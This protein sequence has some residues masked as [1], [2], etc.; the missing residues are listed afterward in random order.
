MKKILLIDCNW[1][2]NTFYFVCK[3]ELEAL[4]GLNWD[5]EKVTSVSSKVLTN[6]LSIVATEEYDE[7]YTFFD[8]GGDNF[9]N[10]L[11]PQY[12][13]HRSKEPKFAFK[14]EL[15]HLKI[16]LET[17]GVLP[18]GKLG[19]EAD[20]LIGSW[21]NWKINHESSECHI[22]TKDKDL[23]Q[24]INEHTSILFKTKQNG[25]N[26]LTNINLDNFQEFYDVETPKQ[27]IDFKAISGDSSDGYRGPQGLG[28]I[29][30]YKLLT[31]FKNLD[32]LFEYV[33]QDKFDYHVLEQNGITSRMWQ[34]II[35]NID[36]LKRNETLATITTD[37]FDTL[38]PEK[39]KE[40]NTSTKPNDL[41]KQINMAS[42]LENQ[43]FYQSNFFFSKLEENLRAM[44]FNNTIKKMKRGL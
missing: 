11:Y 30:T 20:D 39:I 23:F 6:I 13:Q 27:I 40:I 3:K 15:E 43:P 17:I 24:L 14:E 18:I 7:F 32:N 16:A 37:F 35:N 42:N 22:L 25:S 44:N 1:L 36:I 29:G 41:F 33:K 28:E 26:V 38:N 5:P 19:W 2:F 9:R 34:K 31:Y 4:Q 21:V 8:F 12:K 10:K